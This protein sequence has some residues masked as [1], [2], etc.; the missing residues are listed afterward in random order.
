M[1]LF[2]FAYI[3]LA[4]AMAMPGCQLVSVEIHQSSI[5]DKG[6]DTSDKYSSKLSEPK[7]DKTT[8]RVSEF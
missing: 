2:L 8:I 6:D 1:R 3:S 4:V 5:L 7:T